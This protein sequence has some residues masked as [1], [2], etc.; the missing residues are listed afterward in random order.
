MKRISL[1]LLLIAVSALLSWWFL[2]RVPNAPPPP[3]VP[4]V[5]GDLTLLLSPLAALPSQESGAPAEPTPP[6]AAVIRTPPP[7]PEEPTPPPPV[8]PSPPAELVEE[9]PAPPPPEAGT[10]DGDPEGAAAPPPEPEPEPRED[11]SAAAA[12]E[13]EQI[14]RSTTLMEQAT[15]EVTGRSRKG[16]LTTFLCS[17]GDQLDIARYFGEPVVLV[18]RAGLRPG[19]EYYHRLVL[20]GEPGI[21]EVRSPAPLDQYRQYRDLFAFS[22]ESLPRPLRE[23]RR[24]VFVRGDIY[25][26]AALLPPREWGLVIVRRDAA[27]EQVNRGHDGPKRTHDDVKSFT[28]RYVRLPGGAFDIQ[29][30]RISF[31]DGTVV[32]TTNGGM[33]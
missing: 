28:M 33:R 25:L 2:L 16:F 9:E 15:A 32:D 1:Q 10:P 5:P 22:Y 14:E 13:L 24:R 8:E 7:E 26:F 12:G 4:Q 11:L 21:E 6:P 17:A 29:V 27:L 3:S 19:A 20:T 31:D 23:L 30:A 18:P